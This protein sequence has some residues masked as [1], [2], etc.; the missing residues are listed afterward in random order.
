MADGMQIFQGWLKQ[1]APFLTEADCELFRPSLKRKTFRKKEHFL[2]ATQVCR[3][4]GFLVSG[5]F[6]VYYEVEGK[7]VNTH[8]LLPQDFVAEFDSFLSQSPSRYSIEALE[9]SEV[10]AFDFTALQKAYERSHGWERLG[11]ILAET[12]YRRS[13]ERAESFLFLDAESRYLK[14]IR[15]EPQLFERVPLYHIASYLGVERESLSR[16]RKRLAGKPA[17]KSRRRL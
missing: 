12:A 4:M 17:P 6:R 15:E 7:E 9:P 10:V 13:R 1:A 16:I 11:R 8:F 3:S 14:A 2:K 5:V